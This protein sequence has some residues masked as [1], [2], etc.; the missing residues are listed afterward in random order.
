MALT[1][2]EAIRK[3]GL[4]YLRGRAVSNGTVRL[5]IHDSDLDAA[6]DLWADEPDKA[7]LQRR[8]YGAETRNDPLKCVW[9]YGCYLVEETEEEAQATA[10]TTN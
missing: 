5:Y 4:E 7:Y 9:I 3:H 10:G 1:I 8:F 6:I 2:T